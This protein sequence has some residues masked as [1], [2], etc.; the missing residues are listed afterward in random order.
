MKQRIIGIK[1]SY[2]RGT[3]GLV[4]QQ[5]GKMGGLVL[6]STFGFQMKFSA[7]LKVSASKSATSPSC[8][9]LALTLK[10]RHDRQQ[11]SR[12]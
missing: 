4:Q 6:N 8:K 10:N 1:E 11:M 7:K 9:T 3:R 2:P 12:K 5:F